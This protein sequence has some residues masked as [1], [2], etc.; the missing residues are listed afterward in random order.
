MKKMKVI[1]LVAALVLAFCVYAYL[2]ELNEPHEEPRT[3]V[4]VCLVDIPEN[5]TIT[6]DMVEL[7]SVLAESVLPNAVTD[8]NSVVGMVMNSDMFAGEQ[9]LANR[10]VRLGDS[11][12]TSDSL[13]Y[14]V[15]PGMRAV[16]IAVNQ[17]SGLASML[18]PG[19]VVDIIMYYELPEETEPTEAPAEGEEETEPTEET[20]PPMVPHAG[21][22]MQNIKILAVDQTL[23]RG[24][25]DPDG[26]ATV[27]LMVTP[28][29]ALEVSFIEQYHSMRLILRSNLDEEEVIIEDIVL[30]TILGIEEE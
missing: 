30:D 21:Y 20:E 5:T 27:T 23:R 16:T 25:A 7:R 11:D 22:L 3:N 26:Y 9:V 13:A 19:N 28:E 1:A 4:V 24:A 15:E 17:T 14:I 10:L 8:V 12:T 2:G 29:Q 6:A 18:R